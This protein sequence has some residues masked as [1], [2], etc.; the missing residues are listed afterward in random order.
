MSKYLVLNQ[1][2]DK[3]SKEW[4]DW[5]PVQETFDEACLLAKQTSLSTPDCQTLVVL[6]YDYNLGD[7]NPLLGY[8][9]GQESLSY[10]FSKISGE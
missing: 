5:F 7:L 2:M 9:N 4:E 8:I 10:Y 6:E 3:W 1:G